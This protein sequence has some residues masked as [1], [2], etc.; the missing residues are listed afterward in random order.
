M[1]YSLGGCL[2]VSFARYFPLRVQSLICIAGGGLIRPYHVG[3]QSRLLYSS[4][5]L[6]EGLVRWLV[7]RRIRPSAKPLSQGASGAADIM[8]AESKTGNGDASGGKG[9]D[10]ASISRHRPHVSVSSVVSWQIDHHD[11]FI[12]AFLSTI[13]SAPIYAPQEDWEVLRSLLEARRQ[14]DRES[15]PQGLEKGSIL[16]VLGKNDPVVVP[17]ETIED[18][19][20]VLGKDG[21][22]AVV[23]N[24]GHELPIT[25]SSEVSDCID[26]F[27]KEKLAS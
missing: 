2:A 3:W 21:V 15:R 14:N 26:R 13:R 4:G 9:F 19:E 11:G 18:A 23:L 5:L 10:G 20:A 12:P 22:E 7:R 25:L 6:P 1:G 24:A 27:V 16:L 17:S 8:A